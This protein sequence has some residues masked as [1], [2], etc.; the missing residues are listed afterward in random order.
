LDPAGS[1][2]GGSSRRVLVNHLSLEEVSDRLEA[3]V[4]ML[5]GTDGLPRAPVFRAHFIEKEKRVDLVTSRHWKR[6]SDGE[7]TAFEG[8]V[9]PQAAP[10]G[11]LVHQRIQR[12][13]EE[14]SPPS[15][16]PFTG[17]SPYS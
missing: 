9:T 6:A 11:G 13:R 8:S 17:S 3:P 12:L 5:W 14:L 2:V 7:T 16:R 1:E 10:E 15:D 4:G